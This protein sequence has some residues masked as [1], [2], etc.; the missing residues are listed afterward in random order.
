MEVYVLTV[1]LVSCMGSCPDTTE[2]KGVYNCPN[3]AEKALAE[4][5]KYMK[6]CFGSGARCN[7][8]TYTI[9]KLN[10]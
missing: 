8:D 4:Y 1:D 7:I 9:N 3:L 5:Q 2:V 6:E 10:D